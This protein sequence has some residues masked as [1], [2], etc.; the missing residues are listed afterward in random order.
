MSCRG[1]FLLT[2][3]KL[4]ILQIDHSR[5]RLYS[6]RK[7]LLEI[8]W[9][10]SRIRN[11]MRT[12]TLLYLYLVPKWHLIAASII[13]SSTLTFVSPTFDP[14]IILFFIY[15]PINSISLLAIMLVWPYIIIYNTHIHMYNYVSS[16]IYHLI[17]IEFIYL[18]LFFFRTST[19]FI[20]VVS[21]M[22]I[23]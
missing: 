13:S 12:Y 2:I 3:L 11:M 20:Y 5:H 19:Y 6:F 18:L 21:W 22:L 15:L 23:K 9:H 1:F 4:F 16:V 8:Y 17:C 7:S 14:A 10:Y